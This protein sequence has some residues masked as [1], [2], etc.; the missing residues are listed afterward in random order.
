MEE[1]NTIY[2]AWDKYAKVYD[3]LCTLTPYMELV[4]QVTNTVSCS[5][6]SHILDVGCGTGNLLA[7]L[8]TRHPRVKLTGVDGSC[9]MLAEVSRK[10]PES[11]FILRRANFNEK[12]PFAADVFTHLVS[13]NV[14]YAVE[15]PI[16]TL[17]E[18]YRV[19][20]KGGSL[21]L[22]TPK[23]GYE[24]GLILKEHAKSNKTDQ[25][26][27]GAHISEERELAL[28]K[29]AVHDQKLQNAL[30]EIASHNRQIASTSTFHFFNQSGLIHLVKSIG[31]SLI[32]TV[33]CYAKQGLLLQA[34]KE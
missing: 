18:M 5:R 9:T 8:Q 23:I 21:T 13:V 11:Q 14:L 17:S 4:T 22:V 29:E 12:L 1:N 26:W 10:Y 28:I 27:K 20:K 31:F 33:S 15:D 32:S 30:M 3:T 16:Y 24:N 34:R 25:Y 2:A 6:D 19:L 7:S